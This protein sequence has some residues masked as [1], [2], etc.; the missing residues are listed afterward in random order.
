MRAGESE[1]AEVIALKPYPIEYRDI[2]EVISE[3][4][5]YYKSVRQ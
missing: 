3:T 1:Q 2:W 4:I 5:E